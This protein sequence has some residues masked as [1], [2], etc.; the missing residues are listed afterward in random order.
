MNKEIFWESV[1]EP[2]RL[3]VLAILP[4]AIAYLSGLGQEWALSAV[5]VLRFVDKYMHELGKEEKNKSLELG[6]TRF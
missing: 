5:I 6:L 3:L 1:K 2:L 4:F